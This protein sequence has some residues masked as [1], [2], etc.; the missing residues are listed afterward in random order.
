MLFV[1]AFLLK[2]FDSLIAWVLVQLQAGDDLRGWAGLFKAIG[3]KSASTAAA[4]MEDADDAGS[5]D[6]APS[7]SLL[8]PGPSTPKSSAGKPPLPTTPTLLRASQRQSPF[9]AQFESFCSLQVPWLLAAADRASGAAE[10]AISKL[11]AFL[12]DSNI[13]KLEDELV[14]ALQTMLRQWIADTG[15]WSL[16]P[17]ALEPIRIPGSVAPIP[18]QSLLHDASFTS[19]LA[20]WDAGI[21]DNKERAPA[22]TF[23]YLKKNFFF[24][25]C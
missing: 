20:E 10:A 22:P 14:V 7:A 5:F 3:S 4:A 21:F 1:F 11:Q 2:L 16:S 17:G 24:L 25:V 12:V 18:G 23:G 15:A 8:P 9:L 6:S 19:K 13:S